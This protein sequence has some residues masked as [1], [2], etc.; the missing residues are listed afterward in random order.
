MGGRST[1]KLIAPK[2]QSGVNA[3]QGF[4]IRPAKAWGSAAHVA[5]G[6]SELGIDQLRGAHGDQLLGRG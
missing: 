5:V 4:V 6:R 2:M 1:A 3:V